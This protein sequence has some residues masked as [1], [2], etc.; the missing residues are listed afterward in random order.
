MNRELTDDAHPSGH[1]GKL[2]L[3][4]AYNGCHRNEA[5][6]PSF[7]I[8]AASF[9][10]A[11]TFRPASPASVRSLTRRGPARSCLQHQSSRRQRPAPARSALHAG[12]IS[13]DAELERHS[14]R[15]ARPTRTKRI[16]CGAS[17]RARRE[18]CLT[19]AAVFT[20]PEGCPLVPRVGLRMSRAGVPEGGR[21]A[22]FHP[23]VRFGPRGAR[24]RAN[25]RA[26]L[27]V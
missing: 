6:L 27:Q 4:S 3:W 11:P 13:S 24:R 16:S 19:S 8:S 5:Y 25:Y 1:E 21:S 15:V 17:S 2:C 10:S 20:A 18:P 14:L 12:V 23:G 9:Q 26:S 22:N 7:Q